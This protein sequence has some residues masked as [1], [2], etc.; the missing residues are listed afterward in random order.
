MRLG[1][2]ASSV[3][4]GRVFSLTPMQYMGL[5][6]AATAGLASYSYSGPVYAK[7]LRDC[8][9]DEFAQ[10]HSALRSDLLL[11]DAEPMLALLC[12]QWETHA[13]R[14]RLLNNTCDY[15][16][17]HHVLEASNLLAPPETV[18][19]V[20]YMTIEQI[21]MVSWRDQIIQHPDISRALLDAVAGLLDAHR[22]GS[23]VSHTSSS[24]LCAYLVAL[25][26]ATDVKTAAS[27]RTNARSSASASSSTSAS[28]SARTDA[29]ADAPPN[30]CVYRSLET[31]VLERTR[32]YYAQEAQTLQALSSAAYIRH[33]HARILDERRRAQL[34]LH[35]STVGE[36]L[37][38]C[39]ETMVQPRLPALVGDLAQLID[40]GEMDALGKLYQLCLRF[41][42]DVAVTHRAA[43]AELCDSFG[44]LRPPAPRVSSM[45]GSIYRS[46]PADAPLAAASISAGAECLKTALIAGLPAQAGGTVAADVRGGGSSAALEVTDVYTQLLKHVGRVDGAGCMTS[47]A[48][49]A[50]A[51][52]CGMES[53]SLFDVFTAAATHSLRQLLHE[54]DAAARVAVVADTLYTH[55]RGRGLAAIDA[56]L[57]DA[58]KDPTGSIYI[59][60]VSAVFTAMD[61][62]VTRAF[63]RHVYLQNAL[64]RAGNHFLNTNAA[65]KVRR[66]ISAELLAKYCDAFIKKDAEQDDQADERMAT[67]VA[68]FRLLND[69]DVFMT[70]Y[71]AAMAK[72]LIYSKT[73]RDIEVR[74]I[75]HL[76]S[77]CGVEFTAK[78]NR[79]YSDMELGVTANAEFA[80]S[81]AEAGRVLAVSATFQVLTANAWPFSGKPLEITLPAEVRA[82]T[83]CFEEF[84]PRQNRGRRLTWLWK[85]ST[86]EVKAHYPSGFYVVTCSALQL[87]ILEQFNGAASRTVAELAA[88]TGIEPELL[89]AV[90]G[91][92]KPLLADSSPDEYTFNRSF[93][94]KVRRLNINKAIR[95]ERATEDKATREVVGEDRKI[96]L[97]AAIVRIMKTRKAGVTHTALI[98]EV[99]QTMASRFH[100]DVKDIKRQIDALIEKEYM[101][102]SDENKGMYDYVA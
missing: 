23:S 50:V 37:R 19:L 75:G 39:D 40:A 7:F 94:H 66:E 29:Q 2:R 27:A 5:Q 31:H 82:V 45:Y 55:V 79:M 73:N 90:L 41:N 12:A 96:L 98:D 33:V 85:I 71:I 13:L 34:F 28:S 6:N 67:I 11:L 4:A 43:L 97:Q 44:R 65:S 91:S 9:V 77:E 101:K 92:L 54:C 18:D 93:R 36:V 42:A 72:R 100:P 69:K 51:A 48:K 89:K 38:V 58:L 3:A 1:T 60:A 15:Y 22:D 16:N 95:S 26:A 53:T 61:A 56:C 83:S 68:L 59:R 17:R 88:S 86:A 24:G 21:I 80:K 20:P 81:Q 84:Y 78:I 35:P 8:I 87:S 52:L 47:D 49:A 99:I 30:L 46:E 32:I 63:R 10:S 76:R 14:C 64:H 74:M 102:R 70:F 57:D 25:G 62:V